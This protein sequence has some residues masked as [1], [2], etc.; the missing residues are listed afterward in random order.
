MRA[1]AQRAGIAGPSRRAAQQTKQEIVR[2]VVAPRGGGRSKCVHGHDAGIDL[3]SAGWDNIRP[4]VPLSE[5]RL[6]GRESELQL[7]AGLLDAVERSGPAQR[8]RD[9]RRIDAAR[10]H[11]NRRI[12]R[13]FRHP[14][15]MLRWT[16]H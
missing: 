12:L 8:K 15:P 6:C 3:P 4:M 7:L 9:R 14:A 5:S 1:I 10:S 13:F 16:G 2:R 11:A